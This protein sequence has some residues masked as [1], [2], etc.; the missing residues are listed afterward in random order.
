MRGELDKQRIRVDQ[1]QKQPTP[2]CFHR[3]MIR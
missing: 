3:C 2:I 1:D